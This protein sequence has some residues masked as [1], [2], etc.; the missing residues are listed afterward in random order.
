MFSHLLLLWL[1]FGALS[2]KIEMQSIF[3]CVHGNFFKCSILKQT[4]MT[5]AKEELGI[6]TRKTKKHYRKNGSTQKRHYKK[7]RK[8]TTGTNIHLLVGKPSI[9]FECY[10]SSNSS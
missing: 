5:G 1:F 8:I 4:T 7:H 9:L 6:E 2:L 3:Y 10:L